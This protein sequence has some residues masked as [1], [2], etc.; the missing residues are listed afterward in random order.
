MSKK[1]KNTILKG[2]KKLKE[3]MDKALSRK[4]KVKELLKQGASIEE[5]RKI[6]PL[7]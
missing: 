4:D 3:Q 2:N 1:K 7:S 6:V 5:I